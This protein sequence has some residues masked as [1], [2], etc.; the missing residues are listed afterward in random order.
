MK[1]AREQLLRLACQAEVLACKPGNVHPGAAFNDLTVQDFL[2]A[3]EVAAPILARAQDLGVGRAVREAMLAVRGR[4]SSNVNLGICLLLAPLAAVE[5]TEINRF[6]DEAGRVLS[7]L[8]VDDARDVFAAIRLAQPS[9]MG[10]VGD[11][12]ISTVPTVTLLEAMDL[13]SGRDDVARQ[14]VT[15][16][17]DVFETGLSTLERYQP[18]GIEVAVVGLHLNL[19]AQRPDSLIARKCGRNVASDSSRRAGDVLASGWPETQGRDLERSLD[20]W[21]REDGHRRNPE[22]RLILSRQHSTLP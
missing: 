4:V 17:A 6:R 21:L 19:M 14:Y 1:P 2:V 9:G 16:F 5:S 15:R 7:A 10:E 18:Y 8:T 12:D 11:Q 22:P 3:A 20:Q 13:A